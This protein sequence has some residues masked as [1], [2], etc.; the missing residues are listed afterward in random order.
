MLL[1]SRDRERGLKVN[2][3]SEK[4]GKLT[5]SQKRFVAKTIAYYMVRNG[6]S[7]VNQEWLLSALSKNTG[8]FFNT[9]M[10]EELF[11]V[12]IERCGLIR[13]AGPG[14]LE[15]IHN[16]FKE[17]LGAE[18]ASDEGDVGFVV[19]KSS[20]PEW[21]QFVAFA[22]ASE[23]VK[24]ADNVLQ[25]LLQKVTEAE[26]PIR[27]TVATT[28]LKAVGSAIRIPHALSEA[29]NNVMLTIIPPTND[30]EAESLATAGDE[31]CE[32]LVFKV[33]AVQES[34]LCIRT[35]ALN[36]SAKALETLMGYVNDT[37]PAVCDE[38]IRHVNPLYIP[39]YSSAFVKGASLPENV[40]SLIADLDP[41]MD[42]TEIVT[43]MDLSESYISDLSQVQLFK[44]LKKLNLSRT[45]IQNVGPISE[46]EN[47]EILDLSFTAVRSATPLEKLKRLLELYLDYSE[48]DQLFDVTLL[49][50]LK[51]LGLRRTVIGEYQFPP[52]GRD[53]TI[54]VD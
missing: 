38:L 9:E 37:R 42:K 26:A 53:L 6:L 1:D 30:F 18:C 33:R 32:F 21:M 17:Y 5:S 35:L 25:L 10:D 23:N 22:A 15:F 29:V 45:P 8:R 27:R 36:G 41:V 28:F 50:N 51:I 13:E 19:G 3:L 7:Q 54:Y 52:K 24:F 44:E 47:L 34:V 43:M 16:T 46:L 20:E 2:Q 4:Y 48:C 12:F 11:G 40:R 39:V 14:R 49:P 31:I